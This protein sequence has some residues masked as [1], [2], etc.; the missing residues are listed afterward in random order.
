MKKWAPVPVIAIVLIG[1]FYWFSDTLDTEKQDPAAIPGISEPTDWIRA[2]TITV[3]TPGQVQGVMYLVYE[4]PGAPA[5]TK[6]LVLDEYSICATETG[7]LPCMAMS[8]TFDVAFGGKRASVEGIEEDEAVRVRKLQ[9]LREGEEARLGAPG[10]AFIPWVQAVN[11][12]KTCSVEQ[13]M[14]SHA[15]DVYL[16]LQGGERVRAVEPVIDEVFRVLNEEVSCP[17]IS[18]AT[19]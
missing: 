7:A 17:P 4:E 13:V 10:S 3:N 18:V 11:L 14:Q 12:L 16:T 2:G 6:Q 9:I 5:L 19:E 15:L 8:V 1:I